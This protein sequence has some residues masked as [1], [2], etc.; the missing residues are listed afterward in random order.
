MR[1]VASPGPGA[2]LKM[3]VVA[4]PPY[5]MIAPDGSFLGFAVEVLRALAERADLPIEMVAITDAEF[6]PGP[7]TGRYDMLVRASVSPQQLKR[8]DFTLPIW[9]APFA[10]FTRAGEAAGISGLDDLSGRRVAARGGYRTEQLF[11]AQDGGEDVAL[12]DRPAM[13]RALTAGKVDAGLSPSSALETSARQ[14][15]LTD[16]IAKVSPPVF[17]SQRPSPCGPA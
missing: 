5:S 4:F 17:V 13:L 16:R 6:R 14:A 15:G 10:L 12:R 3:G 11:R 1:L 2:T 7:G 9:E 8:M